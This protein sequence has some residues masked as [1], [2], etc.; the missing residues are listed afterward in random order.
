MTDIEMKKNKTSERQLELMKK[1][2]PCKLCGHMVHSSAMWKHRQGPMC[3]KA[4]A[5]LNQ[6]SSQAEFEDHIK[7]MQAFLNYVQKYG[8]NTNV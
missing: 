5:K 1:K 2:K 8:M 4:V 7:A 3:K 6:G